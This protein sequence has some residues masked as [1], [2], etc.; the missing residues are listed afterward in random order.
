MR[1][2]AVAQPCCV[3]LSRRRIVNY[4][5]ESLNSKFGSLFESLAVL[6]LDVVSRIFRASTVSSRLCSGF[7][8][9]EAAWPT[10]EVRA[11]GPGRPGTALG[12][13]ARTNEK[14]PAAGIERRES[15]KIRSCC[16][17]LTPHTP[18]STR[19]VSYLAICWQIWG[20]NRRVN[21]AGTG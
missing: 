20:Q 5:L 7:R 9:G 21:L 1:P 8:S 2:R 16:K 10:T 4:G 11:S 3:I 12:I 13:A 15:L 19:Q 14:S 18:K 17:L 6:K